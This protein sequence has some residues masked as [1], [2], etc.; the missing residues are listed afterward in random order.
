LGLLSAEEAEVDGRVG[1][2]GV[3]RKRELTNEQSGKD[4]LY[5]PSAA[6]SISTSRPAICRCSWCHGLCYCWSRPTLCCRRKRRQ[7]VVQRIRE[8]CKSKFCTAFRQALQI[9]QVAVRA[10]ATRS[11][12]CQSA[13]ACA[14]QPAP[15]TDLYVRCR[16]IHARQK[17]M[18]A[19]SAAA[20][21]DARKNPGV[22]RLPPSCQAVAMSAAH[23]NAER[24]AARKAQRT[25]AEAQPPA[26]PPP[27]AMG[28]SSHPACDSQQLQEQPSSP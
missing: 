1:E 21:Q 26:P 18:A 8:Q 28:S 10:A 2:H 3:K 13:G 4:E 22:R 6:V 25:Q 7:A 24:R 27:I 23:R 11:D 20:R 12:E 15:D 16:E 9:Q 19:S 14:T 5:D 17:Q